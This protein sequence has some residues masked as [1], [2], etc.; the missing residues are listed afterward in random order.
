MNLL[1]NPSQL[2]KLATS[3]DNPLPWHINRGNHIL[4][5][6][7]VFTGDASPNYPKEGAV[8]VPDVY[9]ELFSTPAQIPGVINW[10]KTRPPAALYGLLLSAVGDRPLGMQAAQLLGITDWLHSGGISSPTTVESIGIRNQ[11]TALV[12]AALSPTS[13]TELSI[14]E[15]MKSLSYLLEKQ[16]PYQEAPDLFC[17]DLYKDFDIDVL[18]ALA[19]PTKVQQVS[20]VS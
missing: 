6:N 20:A 18:A 14:K 5:V 10:L 3:P 17:L 2:S 8:Y 13:F 11:V 9:R 12:T 15:G 16:I 19:E 4:A 7:L 1:S